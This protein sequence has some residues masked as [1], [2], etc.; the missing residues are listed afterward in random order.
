MIATD[1]S[2]PPAVGRE[3]VWDY[4]RP[5]RLEPV[6]ARLRVMSVFWTMAAAWMLSLIGKFP[7]DWAVAW[8]AAM[9]VSA[10]LAA[11]WVSPEHRP[12]EMSDDA[13]ATA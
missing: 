2:N 8:A 13:A 5:P 11:V 12:G 6:A 9:S 3:S 7:Y 4:P 10:Q 1:D